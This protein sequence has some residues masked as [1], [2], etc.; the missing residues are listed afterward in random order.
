MVNKEKEEQRNLRK[1]K[2]KRDTTEARGGKVVIGTLEARELR[3]KGQ[4]YCPK[5]K[6]IKLL[7]EFNKSNGDFS[8]HCT[9]CCRELSKKYYNP[10]KNSEKYN[11]NKDAVRDDRLKRKF[12]ITLNE[13]NEKL[14]SQEEQCAIC[15]KSVENNGKALAVDHNHNTGEVR[16]LLCNNC[17]VAVGFVDENIDIARKMIKYLERWSKSVTST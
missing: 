13:Y 10:K 4:K 9:L 2:K 14:F 1:Y 5:C 3:S 8:P 16:G 6:K 11:D 12:G 15:G 7:E 17:N